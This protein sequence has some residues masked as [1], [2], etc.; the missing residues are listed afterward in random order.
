LGGN[1]KENPKPQVGIETVTSSPNA[2]AAQCKWHKRP[3]SEQD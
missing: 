1:K 2:S 3:H